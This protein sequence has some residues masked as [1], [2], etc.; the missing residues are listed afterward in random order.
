MA[1]VINRRFVL[2]PGLGAFC[3]GLGII[4]AATILN[5][6]HDQLSERQVSSLPGFLAT[7]YHATGKFGV[8]LTLVTAGLSV[9]LLGCVFQRTQRARAAARATSTS[10]VPYFYSSADSAEGSTGSSMVLQT[11]KYLAMAQN[12]S[13]TTGFPAPRQVAPPPA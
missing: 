1:S 10:R 2:T 4:L 12:L 8:T 13:G 11:S 3:C 9:I 7:M 6:A 5:L